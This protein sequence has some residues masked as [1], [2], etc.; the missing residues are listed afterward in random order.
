M[1]KIRIGKKS[2]TEEKIGDKFYLY[3]S[4]NTKGD[5]SNLHSFR[6]GIRT[7]RN[8]T[9]MAKN[10]GGGF[11][12]WQN[13]QTALKRLKSSMIGPD[14]NEYRA[15]DKSKDGYPLLVTIEALELN[16]INFV[17]DS[18][19]SVAGISNILIR[20]ISNINKILIDN[21]EKLPPRVGSN[22]VRY[23]GKFIF[24]DIG[25]YSIS[26]PKKYIIKS[27]NGQESFRPESIRGADSGEWGQRLA[28][29]YYDLFNLLQQK[30]EQLYLNMM[31][32]ILSDKETDAVK[33][34]GKEIIKPYKLEILDEK[35]NLI[36]VTNKDP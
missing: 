16:P 33:Y 17:A 29:L 30:D 9:D 8:L 31:K 14:S 4:T 24:N 12:L 6:N 26:I 27:G 13:K 15:F 20:N 32:E 22:Q 19:V 34:V 25:T 21:A 18:E 36:D 2:L 10:Q 23:D 35:G 5:M 7:D 28:V 11:Y 1:I 3:H